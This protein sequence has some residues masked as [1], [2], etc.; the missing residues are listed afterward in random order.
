MV[1]AGPRP[2]RGTPSGSPVKTCCVVWNFVS[3]LG[4]SIPP[5]PCPHPQA[6]AQEQSVPLDLWEERLRVSAPFQN[7]ASPLC[8]LSAIS[9]LFHKKSLK[10][11]GSRGG[12]FS[13]CQCNLWYITAKCD[14]LSAGSECQH[15]G[16]DGVTNS[17]LTG[18]CVGGVAPPLLGNHPR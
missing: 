12:I 5:P 1:G 7:I 11:N 10:S 8:P 2:D 15:T 3:V 6:D 16:L 17:R 4:T 9:L 18:V 13:K 14:H